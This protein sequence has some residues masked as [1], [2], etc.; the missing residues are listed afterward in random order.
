MKKM[1]ICLTML[2]VCAFGWNTLSAQQTAEDGKFKKFLDNYFDAYFKFFPTSGTLAGYH[3]YNDTLEDF[4][5]RA[6]D[7]FH[8]ALDGFNQEIVAKIDKTK[9]SPE[10]QIDYDIMVTALERVYIDFENLLPWE[11]NP[12][13]YN[14]IFINSVHS[15]LTGDFAPLDARVKS[16][17]ERCKQIPNLV[18]RA[19]DNLKTPAQIYTETA[20]EQMPAILAFFRDEAPA[21][22]QGAA[23]SA[24]FTVEQAKAVAALEDYL[25]FLKTEVL[26]RSTGNFR[27]AEAHTRLM[28]L[29]VQGNLTQDELV[30]RSR[31]DFNN[32]RREMLLVAISFHK[33]MYPEIDIERLQK[34]E[35]E[36][37]DYI[38]QNVFNKIQTEHASRDGF[39]AAIQKAADG[40]RQFLTEKN[41]VELPADTLAIENMPAYFRG[42][43]MNRLILPGPFQAAGSSKFQIAPIP[44]GWSAEKADA[45]LREY[46][47][48]FID[49]F[50]VQRVFP[51]MFV[52]AIVNFKTG[53]LVRKA[54]PNQALLR[55]WPVYIEEM[56]VTNG[57]KD[58]DLRVR[59]NQLKLMLKNIIDFQMELNIHQGE[60]TKEQVVTYMTRRGFQT[61]AEA[62][63]KWNHILLNPGD[64]ALAYIGFQEI[65]DLE[66]DYKAVKG[67][68]FEARDFLKAL[69]NHGAVPLRTL[70]MKLTQ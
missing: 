40:V 41:L 36:M 47:D 45:F 14:E 13:F 23:G 22:A 32:I 37:R 29:L 50:T 46:N 54:A 7:R 24:A 33:I 6:V 70:K 56:L 68:D 67:A 1:M 51:G 34:P 49:F 53:S 19:K 55:G 35:E 66:K 15:V 10:G 43:A 44:E 38:I 28:R 17:A 5:S 61:E 16:A 63:N 64:A 25:N 27:W 4:S 62:E 18:R 30:A 2:A 42:I 69:L 3:K 57:Y 39:I 26:P 21:L 20:I 65:L 12:L 52:P 9:L 11:Y 59:L 58:F 60:M 48:F 8:D 31:A